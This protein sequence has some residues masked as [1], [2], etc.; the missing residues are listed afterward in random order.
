M[1]ALIITSV[2]A[3]AGL[4]ASYSHAQTATLRCVVQAC[5]NANLPNERCQVDTKQRALITDFGDSFAVKYSQTVT[6]FSPTLDVAI[7]DFKTGEAVTDRD[8]F[9]YMRRHDGM[10]YALIQTVKRVSFIFGRCEVV[11]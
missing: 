8:R 5:I 7:D 11:S 6:S 4:S 10:A 1:K 2:I 3:L 9:L